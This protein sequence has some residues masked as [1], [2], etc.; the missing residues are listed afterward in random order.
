VRVT[1]QNV[2]VD[3]G[4]HLDIGETARTFGT[5]LKEHNNIG[6]AS[7]PQHKGPITS[8]GLARL[9]GLA[10]FAGLSARL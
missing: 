4:G 9:D 5:K 6:R 8:G 1:W 10:R 7:G 2:P 3:Y